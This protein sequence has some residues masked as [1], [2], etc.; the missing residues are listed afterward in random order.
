MGNDLKEFITSIRNQLSEK[1]FNIIEF[2]KTSLD[3]NITNAIAAEIINTIEVSTTIDPIE[4]YP[5]RE[6]LVLTK[7]VSSRALSIFH[8]EQITDRGSVFQAHFAHVASLQDVSDFRAELLS[9]KKIARAAH[10]IFCYRLIDP[11]TQVVHH[12]CDDDGEKAAGARLAELVRLMHAEG[13][14]NHAL[15]L[16]SLHLS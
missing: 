2:A 9:D 7:A 1:M 5:S 11:A 14:G 10:N 13:I 16:F 4:T 15:P 6:S 8:G 12:D 3:N